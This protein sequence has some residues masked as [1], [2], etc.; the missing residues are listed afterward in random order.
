[1]VVSFLFYIKVYTK[2]EVN[3]LVI[4]NN[5]WLVRGRMVRGEDLKCLDTEIVGL[6]PA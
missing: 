4:I 1:M 3:N 5:N 2:V 6:N